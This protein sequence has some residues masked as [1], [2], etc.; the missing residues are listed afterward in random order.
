[1]APKA[2]AGLSERVCQRFIRS[3]S[4]PTSFSYGCNRPPARTHFIGR[5]PFKMKATTLFSVKQAT[6]MVPPH[7]YPRRQQP[8]ARRFRPVEPQP[9]P[10][11]APSV[12]GGSRE[13]QP[14]WPS[15]H[16]QSPA[17]RY[18]S[19]SASGRGGGAAP[20]SHPVS[21][22]PAQDGAL[23]RHRAAEPRVPTQ[24]AASAQRAVIVDRATA[25]SP[26]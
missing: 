18:A 16:Q 17:P 8:G 21:A 23:P 1:M 20:T 12:V 11:C 6:N 3:S 19:W 2:R 26:R 7:P 10:G 25:P 9:R 15:V 5:D 14:S 22:L 13:A 24:P 4:N